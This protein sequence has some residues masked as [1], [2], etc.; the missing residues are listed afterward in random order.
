[1]SKKKDCE[2]LKIHTYVHS[3]IPFFTGWTNFYFKHSRWENLCHSLENLSE[4]SRPTWY[5]QNSI[6]YG[7]SKCLPKGLM[8]LRLGPQLSRALW[9]ILR[10]W[11]EDTCLFFS[12]SFI[13]MRAHVLKE[14]CVPW[15]L[16]LPLFCYSAMRWV[17]FPY[18]VLLTL[19][20]HF[21]HRPKNNRANWL[22]SETSQFMSQNKHSLF[23]SWLIILGVCFSGRK[24]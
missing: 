19:K 7:L 8:L 1:L 14:G 13:H 18:H 24:L 22:W 17:V 12:S 3:F 6:C 9:E 11:D 2:L 10:S 20:I 4:K 16:P 21:R 23:V 5:V 15:S